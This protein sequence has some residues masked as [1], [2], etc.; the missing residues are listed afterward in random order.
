MRKKARRGCLGC[1]GQLIWQLAAVLLLG[2]VLVLAFT[3]VFYPWAFYLGGKFHILPYWYGW[4]TLHA[5]SGDYVLWVQFEPTPRGSRII[6][7]SDLTGTAHLCSP[8]GEEFRMR[9][10]G[11]MRPHLS[12]STNGEAIGLYMNTWSWYGEFTADHRPSLEFRG[13]WQNPD[14]AM[15]DHGSI[16]R[17]FLPDGSV[18]RGHDANHP[19]NGEVVPITLKPGSYSEFKAACAAVR[20]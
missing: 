4:G 2:S 18:Y 12:L 5:K 19:Y 13:R 11:G 16:F 3:G 10:G 6:P 20:R 17:A 14:L 15:D 7:H 9:L 8:R 1:L